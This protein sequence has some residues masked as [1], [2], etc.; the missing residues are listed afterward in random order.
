MVFKQ[1][2]PPAEKKVVNARVIGKLDDIYKL[3]LKLKN[4]KDKLKFVRKDNK[5][6]EKRK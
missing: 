6:S 4:Y 3:C 2:F 5:Y 1:M